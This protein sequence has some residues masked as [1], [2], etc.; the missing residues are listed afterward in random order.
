M[1]INKSK[2]QS[3]LQYTIFATQ[4]HI[5]QSEY[6]L[7]WSTS[8]LLG[9]SKVA[10]YTCIYIY[11][12]HVNTWTHYASK[13]GDTEKWTWPTIIK[14][15]T[16][17]FWNNDNINQQCLQALFLDFFMQYNGTICVNYFNY[18]RSAN[19]LN[20]RGTQ[21]LLIYSTQY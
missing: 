21:K 19:S 8:F 16:K 9:L 13:N 7:Q 5:I 12:Y 17:L 1:Y 15:A 20:V 18:D 10:V 11:I 14:W 2:Q 4:G 6:T 3:L